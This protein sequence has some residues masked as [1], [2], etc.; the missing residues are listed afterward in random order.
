MRIVL[1]PTGVNPTLLGA[2]YHKVV[3]EHPSDELDIDEMIR[4]IS[5]AVVAFGFHENTV[6]NYF[7]EVANG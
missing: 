3:I 6:A 5:T 2:V 1:E 7:R 4:L